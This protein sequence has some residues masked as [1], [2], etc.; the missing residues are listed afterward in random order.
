MTTQEMR[1]A[2]TFSFGAPRVAFGPGA[3][4]EAGD[5]LAALGVTSAFVV[6]DRFVVDSGLADELTGTLALAGVD[7]AVASVAGEPTEDSV[8][9]AAAAAA[10]ASFDG[11][12]G[13]GGGSAIDTA[14]LCALLA[15]HGGDAIDYVAAPIGGG[16]PLPGPLPP[17][18]ALPTTAGT[19]SEVTTVAVVD[20]PRLGTK[21]GVSHRHLQPTLA[22][23]DP[24][25]TVSCPPGVTAATGI[26]ALMHALEAYLSLPYDRRAFAPAATRPPYQGA[27]P[28][29]D[30]LCERAIAL[31]GANLRTA[32][33]DGADLDARSA[34]SI[35]AT[36]AGIAF[37][38]AGVHVPHALAYPIASLAHSWQPPGYGGATFV[39]HGY[40]VAVTAPA[41]LRLAEAAVAER[42][43]SAARL[44]GGGDDLAGA[45][46]R[47][48]QDIG[49]PTRLR[50][51]GYGEDDVDAIV[52][53][54]L[55]QQRLL[56]GA[57]LQ[58]AAEQLETIL[59]E[60]L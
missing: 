30:A 19:G 44:L 33:R 56:V 3:A 17:I 55:E 47:L 22:L 14:K 46:E 32:V 12:V 24:L 38:I 1:T 59:R 54:A 4:A 48:M 18:V 13:V 37:S 31:I 2:T 45:V 51:V 11:F 41:F 35:A 60:S 57:P 28:L 16:S 29:T 15:V 7:A 21:A 8:R 49:A 52:A 26:D 23:V 58:V 53:G 25:L 34:M 43:A 10:A 5:Q 9:T 42:S 20:F 36:T 39:P 6:C 27:N 40:A 50:E